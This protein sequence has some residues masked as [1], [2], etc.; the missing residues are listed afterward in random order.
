[1]TNGAEGTIFFHGF[2][3]S[4]VT[5]PVALQPGKNLIQLEWR[6]TSDAPAHSFTAEVVQAN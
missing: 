2:D 4:F 1:M 6:A 3:A 5:D